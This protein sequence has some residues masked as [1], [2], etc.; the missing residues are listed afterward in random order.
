MNIIVILFP[1]AL[2]LG[3]AGL[4]AFFW[5]LRSGQ[6]DDLE[7]S[8]WRVLED[9]DVDSAHSSVAALPDER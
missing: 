9:D 3:L 8:G 7:G 5:C 6:Y 2:G 4:G 1:L